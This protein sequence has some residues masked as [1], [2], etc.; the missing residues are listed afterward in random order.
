[1]SKINELFK[2]KSILVVGNK[3]AASSKEAAHDISI[4]RSL[5]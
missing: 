3:K 1:M 5:P 4:A 2:I